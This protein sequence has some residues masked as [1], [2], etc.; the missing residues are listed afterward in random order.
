MTQDEIKHL[1]SLS[2]IAIDD[3]TV[4]KFGSQITAIL[5]YVSQVSELVTD[6]DQKVVGARYNVLRPDVITNEPG[7]YTKVIMA[8]MPATEGNYMKVKKILATDE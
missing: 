8:E 1:A 6:N 4:E 7:Q 2:R 5:A 3:T